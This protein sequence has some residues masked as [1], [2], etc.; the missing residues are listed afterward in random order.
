MET[1]VEYGSSNSSTLMKKKLNISV[2]RVID[3]ILLTLFAVV[4]QDEEDVCRAQ[5]PCV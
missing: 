4:D 1:G 3:K 2:S 5:I